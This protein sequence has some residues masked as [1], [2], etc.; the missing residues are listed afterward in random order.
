MYDDIIDGSRDRM[1]A[2]E[3]ATWVEAL[4]SGRYAQ[5]TGALEIATPSGP[6]FCCLGVRCSIL[7]K[8]GVVDRTADFLGHVQYD[9]SLG[10][11]PDT[12]LTIGLNN[13][14]D[15]PLFDADGDSHSLA[16]LNDEGFTFAQ[17]ADLIDYFL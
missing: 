4:R 3:K 10:Y 11:L 17:I 12:A 2:T 15:L 8:A 5:A 1:D 14:G 16:Q 7:A 13:T 6:A 9:G